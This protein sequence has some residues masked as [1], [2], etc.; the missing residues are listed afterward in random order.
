M[1]SRDVK[2]VEATTPIPILKQYFNNESNR[3]EFVSDL[4]DETAGD[5]N[6]MER[7]LG[8]GSGSWYRRQALLRA[9][10]K[11][12]YKVLDVGAGTGLVAREAIRIV[13]SANLVT[14]VD[15]S[16]GM[17]AQTKL[18]AEVRLLQGRAEEL[19]VDDSDYDFVSMGYAL[20]HLSDLGRVFGEFHR[21]LRPGGSFS[22]LEITRPRGKLASI[23]L[24]AY[25]RGLVPALGNLINRHKKTKTLWQY[26]WDTIEACV[27]PE[28]VLAHLKSAGFE[29]VQREVV[30]GLFSEYRGNKPKTL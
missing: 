20:R 12:G 24:C 15:P 23:L 6:R 16:P 8:L 22:V 29:N 13:G 25:M 1:P 7:L 2:D 21:V 18:P 3:I 5:Y 14:G 27:P 30:L 28:Q 17:L 9:G 26:Y 19:P 4:F 10:L 11:A